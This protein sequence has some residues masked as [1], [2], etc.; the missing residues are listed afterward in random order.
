MLCHDLR[1]GLV[2][3]VAGGPILCTAEILHI[4]LYAVPANLAEIQLGHGLESQIVYA[5]E[6]G[7]PLP[8]T[9]LQIGNL[10]F[11][12]AVLG[13]GIVNANEHME[14]VAADPADGF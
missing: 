11:L 10:V 13:G 2:I 6:D 1:Q 12:D 7:V 9:G 8:Q 5:G 3:I 4:D 14:P